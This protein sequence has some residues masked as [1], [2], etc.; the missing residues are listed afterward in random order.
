MIVCD[1]DTSFF[2]DARIFF[3]DVDGFFSQFIVIFTDSKSN[4]L[5]LV[6]RKVMGLTFKNRVQLYIL[7]LF[8]N[9]LW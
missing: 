2:L 9:V 5:D 3:D 8:G 6:F 4:L 7:V 1:V